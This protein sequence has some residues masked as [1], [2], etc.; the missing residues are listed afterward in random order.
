MGMWKRYGEW[1]S[2]CVLEEEWVCVYRLVL[3]SISKVTLLPSPF[4]IQSHT[5]C[6]TPFPFP[7]PAPL[8]LSQ[9]LKDILNGICGNSH[10]STLQPAGNLHQFEQVYVCDDKQSEFLFL[11]FV[12]C[13]RR[14]PYHLCP[15]PFHLPSIHTTAV[16][17][18]L[19]YHSFNLSEQDEDLRVWMSLNESDSNPILALQPE[20]EKEW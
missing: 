2:S 14:I 10:T 17:F 11:N 4:H 12:I 15:S 9:Q 8:L 3:W 6:F 1:R 13:I 16:S 19:L 20:E 7:F 5:S 18:S